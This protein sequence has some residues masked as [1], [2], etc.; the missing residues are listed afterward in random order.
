MSA[1]LADHAPVVELLLTTSF[2]P[3]PRPLS[4]PEMA[5]LF[6]LFEAELPLFQQVQAAGPMSFNFGEVFVQVGP[7][8]TRI[9]FAS[10]SSGRAFLFQ[11]DRMSYGWNRIAPLSGKSGYPGFENILSE[12]IE[13]WSVVRDWLKSEVQTIVEPAVLEVSYADGFMLNVKDG[14]TIGLGSSLA[15]ISHDHLVDALN[16]QHSWS[17]PLTSETG[18]ATYSIS[19][20]QL[21]PDG[22]T[23][24]VM[25]SVGLFKPEAGW[26]GLRNQF[27]NVRQELGR[28]FQSLVNSGKLSTL[29]PL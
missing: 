18:F 12:A 6:N 20:P 7:E 25:T 5:N 2:T 14:Q 17:R 29:E 28:A 23:A 19:G 13:K 8:P 26:S 24:E 22:S 11:N 16:Y 21:A 10:P 1:V 9:R 15:A 4:V 3:S 27:L